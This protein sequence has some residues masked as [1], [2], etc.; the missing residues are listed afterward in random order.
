MSVTLGAGAEAAAAAMRAE[1][2]IKTCTTC[3]GQATFAGCYRPGVDAPPGCPGIACPTCAGLSEA[4]CKTRPDCRPDYCP[5]CTGQR[6]TRCSPPPDPLP[7]CPPLGCPPPIPCSAATTLADC[8]AHTDCHS[9]F[10][11]NQTCLCASLGCCARFNRCADGD[12]AL[13]K[14]MPVCD[15][16]TPYCE[17][18]YV[19][20]YTNACYEGCVQTK[21]C[22]P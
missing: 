7:V 20:S 19:V 8:A 9:V 15:L 22:A 13:C 16:A 11:D 5:E 4:T 12:K 3:N 1:C 17:G 21:D 2:A 6:F 18:P 14:G 10:V